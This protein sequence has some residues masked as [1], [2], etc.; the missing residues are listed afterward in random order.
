[1]F[2]LNNKHLRKQKVQG[3]VKLVKNFITHLNILMFAMAFL[4]NLHFVNYF[5]DFMMGKTI[6]ITFILNF[7]LSATLKSNH[8]QEPIR[9][10]Q[11]TAEPATTVDFDGGSGIAEDPFLVSTAEQLNHVRNLPNA[12]FKQIANINLDASPWNEGEG[13][14]PIGDH[15][16]PFSGNYDGDGHR[17]SNLFIYRP[18]ETYVGLFGN[19]S[20]AV[21][22]NLMLDNAFVHGWRYVGGLA[23]YMENQS[24]VEH[25]YIESIDLH[26]TQ[27]HGGGLAGYLHQ[28]FVFRSYSSGS[29]SRG[30]VNEWNSIGGLAG[31][32]TVS[33]DHDTP[34][35]VLESF[36]TVNL[37]SENHNSYGGLV[38][39][40]WQH[41]SIYNC[42]TRGSVQGNGSRAAGLVAELSDSPQTKEIK[43]SFAASYV[44][45]PGSGVS[46]FLGYNDGGTFMGNFWDMEVSDQYGNDVAATGKTTEEMKDP[47][48]FI[49]AEWDMG[50]VWT[51]DTGAVINDGYPVLRWQL[52]VCQSPVSVTFSNISSTSANI[53]WEATKL[54]NSWTIAWGE[55]G[56]EPGETGYIVS[57]THTTGFTIDDLEEGT[58][59]EVYIKSECSDHL[60]SDWSESFS[61]TTVTPFVFEGGGHYC[62]GDD[63]THID[64]WLSG[65]EMHLHYQLF[66][67]DEEFGEPIQ[68]T[69]EAL[70]WNN[71]SEGEYT[72]LAFSDIHYE[73]MA[74]EVVVTEN[75]LPEVSF[76][77]DDDSI[78]IDHAPIE[79]SGGQPEGGYYE[80]NGVVDG[81]FHPEI[82]GEG[83]HIIHYF[84][85]NEFGC[86]NSDTAML[87]VDLCVNVQDVVQQQKISI[88]PNPASDVIYL[89]IEHQN[90]ELKSI[91]I[92]NKLGMKLTDQHTESRQ[93]IYPVAISHLPKGFYFVRLVFDDESHTLP[94]IIQ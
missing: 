33:S 29:L 68:G 11:Q 57:G 55:A 23:G 79:L 75:P 82:A 20:G 50:V 61:F 66:K 8:D 52:D 41:A 81:V 90:N 16:N 22:K 73:W 13:W 87:F 43:N 3:W 10:Q 28:S 76:D 24:R 80:G 15:D 59:Y 2:I 93:A 70:T 37:T 89:E 38:G 5:I 7:L 9:W 32:V 51:I 1:M 21:V 6:L 56:F 42:Y 86:V 84:Y 31:S 35:M 74:G 17:I 92:I 94:L 53:E 47:L 67:L 49:D 65:S 39:S 14:E 58:T 45:A 36:S 64:A 85:E 78:C 4:S 18:E 60:Y 34:S 71:I 69:G 72:V 88:Y 40:V 25:I 62:E 83:E 12:Y 63:P 48:T 91:S 27:R 26:I 54:A 44:N 77:L 19:T 30:N 46:G